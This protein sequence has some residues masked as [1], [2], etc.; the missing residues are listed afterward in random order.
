[1]H[2]SREDMRLSAST[3]PGQRCS[4]WVSGQQARCSL[5][6]AR[7][8]TASAQLTA[9]PGSCWPHLGEPGGRS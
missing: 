9:S 3:T 8:A 2:V 4:H 5:W 7:S 1:M 6:G